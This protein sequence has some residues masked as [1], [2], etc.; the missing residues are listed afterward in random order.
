MS[1]SLS[2]CARPQIHLSP[3]FDFWSS[4]TLTMAG[5]FQVVALPEPHGVERGSIAR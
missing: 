1:L 5:I 3:D 2:Q 4:S